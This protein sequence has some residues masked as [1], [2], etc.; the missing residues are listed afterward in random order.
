MKNIIV[1]GGAGYIGSHTVKNLI[2]NG[3]NPI[4]VDNLVYGHREAVFTD[5]FYN[6]DIG[7]K[8]ALSAVFRESEI[9]AVIHFAGYAYVGESVVNPQKYYKNNVVNTVNVLECMLENNVKNIVFSSSC[10]TYGNQ[11]VD[12]IDESCVQ[13][14]INPYGWSKYMVE[15]ILDDYDRAYGVKSICLRYFNAAGADKDGELMEKHI[16]EPHLIPALIETA[17]GKRE[18][19]TVFGTDYDTPDGTCIRDY[20]HVEDLARAHVLALEKLFEKQKSYKVNL[21][22]GVGT[23]IKD[24]ILSVERVTGNK[25]PVVYAQRREGDPAKLVSSNKFAYE[26]LGWKPEYTNIDDIVKSAYKVFLNPPF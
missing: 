6:V 3:Y 16:P 26:L 25:I 21:G 13:M 5:R 8:A 4:V 24:L 20:T 19:V 15:R 2:K 23:S 1:L 14:P 22:T 10:T 18:S 17:M 9:D 7:D 11:P 12:L